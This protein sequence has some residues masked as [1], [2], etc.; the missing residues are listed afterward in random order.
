MVLRFDIPMIS[1]ARPYSN[2]TI[3]MMAIKRN[4]KF[5]RLQKIML[6]ECSLMLMLNL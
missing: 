6:K 5:R 3:N 4:V 2:A 1:I